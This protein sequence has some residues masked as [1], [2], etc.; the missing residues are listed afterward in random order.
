MGSGTK[1]FD[2]SPY[3]KEPDCFSG[4]VFVE[5]QLV[6]P[7]EGAPQPNITTSKLALESGLSTLAEYTLVYEVSASL[8]DII[9]ES[10]FIEITF[11]YD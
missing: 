8:G 10:A 2:V 1:Y 9:S 11:I 5:V 3:I 6:T 4:P 7:F